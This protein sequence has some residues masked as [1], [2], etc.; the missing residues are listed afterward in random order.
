MA[1]SA[2]AS[3]RTLAQ[4]DPHVDARV[5]QVEGVGVALGAVVEDRTLRS[6]MYDRSASFCVVDGGHRGPSGFWAIGWG[7]RA[8]RTPA[9]PPDP[10]DLGSATD[11]CA[12]ARR[13][14]RVAELLEVV[15]QDGSSSTETVRS[16]WPTSRMRP[17]NTSTSWM[18]WP[19]G[20]RPGGP[21]GGD[22]SS[23]STA[24][25]GWSLGDLDRVDE[26]VELLGDLLERCRLDVDDDGDAAE[27]L[28]LLQWGHRSEARY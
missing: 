7:G 13:S 21:D 23:R 4:T 17:P 2:L 12:A 15:T 5:L 19:G 16:S 25:S 6:A 11:R 27:R 8:R 9:G 1:F 24:W 3:R 26:L 22:G 20:C 14:H 28:V 10:L 18:T